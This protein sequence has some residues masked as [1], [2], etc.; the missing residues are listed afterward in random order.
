[1][2][3][4]YG[5]LLALMANTAAFFAPEKYSF[6]L[7]LVAV[8]MDA[9]FGTWVS[10]RSGNFLLSKLGRVTSFK[11]LSYGASLMLVFMVEKLIHDD[12]FIGVKVA[13]AWAVACEFWSMSASIL[14]IWP[15]AAF[16][17]IM[18]RH[19]KGEI[20]AKL[21]AEID[22]ILPEEKK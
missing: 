9:L 6:L 12:G 13:A 4:A 10:L 7:V 15:E 1:M 21:G 11:M 3:S 14:I 5:W 22:D 17:R 18:R 20:A 19:L 8:V 2:A 16:F